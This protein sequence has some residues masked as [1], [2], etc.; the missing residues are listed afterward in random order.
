VYCV[1][2]FCDDEKVL[3]NAADIT[4]VQTCQ[5]PICYK[6]SFVP[7]KQGIYLLTLSINFSGKTLLT[8]MKSK[9]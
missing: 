1:G 9:Q 7:Q 5:K 4:H 8:A 3:A 6:N 2:H